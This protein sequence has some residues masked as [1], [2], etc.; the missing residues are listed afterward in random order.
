MFL[1]TCFYSTKSHSPK[2]MRNQVKL[3]SA[4]HNFIL[5]DKIFILLTI[6]IFLSLIFISKRRQSLAIIQ[7]S[8][9]QHFT[10]IIHSSNK[11]KRR[12]NKYLERYIVRK[13]HIHIYIV[14]PESVTPDPRYESLV[15]RGCGDNRLSLDCRNVYAYNFFIKHSNLGDFLYR[16]MDDTLLNLTNLEKLIDQL[17]L[18]YDPYKHIVFRGFLNDEVK[19]KL[20]LGGGSGWLMSR[21]MVELHNIPFYSFRENVKHSFVY[22][23]DTTETLILRKIGFQNSEVYVDS[24]WAESGSNEGNIT[25]YSMGNFQNMQICDLNRNLVPIHEMVALH[26]V[27]DEQKKMWIESM[28]FPS[29]VYCFKANYSQAVRMCKT[30]KHFVNEKLSFKYLKENAEFVTLDQIKRK[31]LSV[32][33]YSLNYIEKY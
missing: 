9:I 20:F 1:K 27:G 12:L 3:N 19:G 31:N 8:Q 23:D 21:A 14:Y 18:I 16:A 33:N 17:R 2:S 5:Y 6:I 15:A 22:H 30:E 10:V 11:T 29:F 26:S 28:N 24:R 4:N 32:W 25:E 7:L 13:P